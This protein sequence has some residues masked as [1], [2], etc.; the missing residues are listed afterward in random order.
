MIT[1]S[2]TFPT[3]HVQDF[4]AIPKSTAEISQLNPWAAKHKQN[5][6]KRTNQ[7]TEFLQISHCLGQIQAIPSHYLPIVVRIPSIL[8]RQQQMYPAVENLWGL[9][10]RRLRS[11]HQFS[12]RYPGTSHRWAFTFISGFKPSSHSTRQQQM[13]P[14]KHLSFASSASYMQGFIHRHGCGIRSEFTPSPPSRYPPQ[15]TM[16]RKIAGL[17][18]PRGGR[19]TG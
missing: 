19:F 14:V 8:S 17:D 5:L 1:S 16:K 10:R 6:R 3:L 18:V 15:W 7:H 11:R 13:Y 9:S 12:P 4:D 2:K